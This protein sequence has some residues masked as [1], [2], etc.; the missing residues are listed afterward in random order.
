MLFYHDLFWIRPKGRLQANARVA[1]FTTDSF[2]ARLYAFENDVLYANS[3]PLYNGKG[4]RSYCNMRY[5]IGRQIDVWARYSVSRY[6][7]AETVGTGLD[8]SSGPY[9]SEVKIQMR[10]QW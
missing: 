8:Q 6:F 9:R 5:K 1:Y 2:D 10:Y 4:W 3:F 7:D